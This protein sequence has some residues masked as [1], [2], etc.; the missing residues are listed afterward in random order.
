MFCTFFLFV[1][2]TDYFFLYRKKEI[3][4]ACSFFY[5]SRCVLQI[6]K[7]FELCKAVETTEST[8]NGRVHW[9]T[10]SS[11]A[12]WITRACSDVAS[13]SNRSDVISSN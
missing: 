7:L 6:A 12:D 11:S 5:C 9:G 10:S 2:V 3:N 4:Y 8:D 13:A 1:N